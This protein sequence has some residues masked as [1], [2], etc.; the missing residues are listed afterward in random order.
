[1]WWSRHRLGS[2]IHL[3]IHSSVTHV[4]GAGPE[5]G[6]PRAALEGAVEEAEEVRHEE[7]D[8]DLRDLLGTMVVMSMVISS[9][10]LLRVGVRVMCGLQRGRGII[11]RD[12]TSGSAYLV[13][14]VDEVLLV[15][16][17]AQALEVAV[18]A[19][20]D[21]QVDNADEDGGGCHEGVEPHEL[22]VVVRRL[23][24]VFVRVEDV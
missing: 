24:V 8:E 9:L 22:E 16:L 13:V 10:M 2:F 4:E 6:P 12:D 1:M 17:V 19:V 7:D 14:D 5:V 18:D 21:A 20:R 11:L 3:F 23:F 15:A